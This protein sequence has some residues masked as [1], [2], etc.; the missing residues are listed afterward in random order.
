MS[1]SLR[2]SAQELK[3]HF[4]ESAWPIVDAYIDAALGKKDLASLNSGCREEVWDLIKT[5]M[6]QSSDKLELNI[7]SPQDILKAV[8][9][10]KCTFEEGDKLLA[11]YKKVKDIETVGLSS[12]NGLDGLTVVIQNGNIKP[13]PILIESSNARIE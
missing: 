2:V 6:V 1:K 4:L 11:L 3:Q 13:E 7:E 10:G 8:E 12:G 9:S 5:L